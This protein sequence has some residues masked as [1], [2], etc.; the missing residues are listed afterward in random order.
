MK[1]IEINKSEELYQGKVYDLSVVDD[2]SYCVNGIVVHNCGC[3]TSSN[4]SIHYPMASLIN[5]VF[6]VKQSLQL[7]ADSTGKKLP[8]IIADGGIRNYSDVIK[9]LALG[10]DYVMIGSLFASLYE[11]CAKTVKIDGIKY[12]EFYGMASKQGQIAINGKKTK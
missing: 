5:D 7:I 4:T 11:S 9:A 12:K 3:I 10:S 6:Q 1:L 8:Y 2:N